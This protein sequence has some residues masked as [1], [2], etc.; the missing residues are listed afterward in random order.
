MRFLIYGFGPYRHFQENISEKILPK[1]PRRRWFNK[2]V[3]PVKFDKAQF[4]KAVTKYKPDIILGLGQCSRG[5][6]LRIEARAVNKR[7][8]S[9]KERPR[10]IIRGGARRLLTNLKLRGGRQARSSDNAGN[11][12][13][14]YSM[15]IIL[16][17]LKRR[18]LPTRFGFV[19]IP[20]RYESRKALRNL[21]KVIDQ[22]RA[23]SQTDSGANS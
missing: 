3:F 5:K 17:F 11:Y 7:R 21:V 22:L 13:C 4:I 9:E 10:P 2:V 15:Y 12:V 8:N 20:H 1:L 23:E 19:H 16:D 18:R 6:R 14:N